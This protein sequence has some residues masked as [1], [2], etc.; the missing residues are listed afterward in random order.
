M[1]VI[2]R[3][4][5]G[6][7]GY[8]SGDGS[9]PLSRLLRDN[10]LSLVFQPIVS[11]VD[12]SIYAHE[13]LI[14]GPQGTPLHLPV[15]LL[16]AAGR[17]GLL[18]DFEVACVVCALE[19]WAALAQPGRLFVKLSQ[20]ALL[21][22]ANTRFSGSLLELIRKL[23]LQR[24][25]LVIEITEREPVSDIGALAAAVQEIHTAGITLALD[26]FG[27]GRSSLRLWSEIQPDIVKIDKYFC[28]DVSRHATKLQT[29]RALIQI[30]EIF[31]TT[32]VFEG[33]ETAE[34]LRVVRDLGATLC[35][36]FY[37]GRPD[38][39]PREQMEVAA[40]QVLQDRRIA[41][42]PALRAASVPG[43]QREMVTIKAPSVTSK[44]THDELESLFQRQ[45]EL[46]AVAIVDDDL[47]IGL[48][49]RR[50]F[51]ERCA[52]R[53]F[54]ELYG[55]KPC[56]T[57][58]NLSPRLIERNHDIEQLVG[59]LTS[60][61][62]RYLIEG[63]IVTNNG[64]YTG[65]GTGDQLVRMVTESRIEAARHANPLTFLPGNIP[66][67]E[68]I[69]R[70]L[71]SGG[72]F[73]ACYGDL[74]NFK[75]FND[76]YGYWS[77]DEMI[78]LMARLTLAHCDVQ[79]DF[80]GHVGGDD[81]IM[82]FQSDDWEARCERL[83]A[84]F[85]THAAALYDDAGREAGGIEAEDRHGVMRFFPITSL[86][87][88]AVRIRKGQFRSAEMVANAAAAAKRDAKLA[89]AGLSVRWAEPCFAAPGS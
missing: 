44:T 45:P 77:G 28:R 51:M 18:L 4:P 71:G 9:G 62:Q 22:L 69:E 87:I 50:Q 26:D 73:V 37:L 43:R 82:L 67:T 27:D 1:A 29:L 5:S 78:R 75:P 76:H 21:Q 3:V 65:L 24:R 85:N 64:R 25:M 10:A 14:R 39:A 60:Q 8:G 16:A 89:N 33:I 83:V 57:F 49:D 2:D 13:A 84:A 7:L 40:L 68:H 34:D 19:R 74:N 20:S 70:L 41:V 31:G 11:M 30:A 63:F 55:S 36:G 88:G 66:V 23:G 17:E 15:A 12:A 32:L 42:L 38:A 59:I 61:D 47:P 35:Q 48:V 58:A 53:Y 80:V 52:K 79:R 46:H 6:M 81:F 72:E 86:S 54:K 56:L